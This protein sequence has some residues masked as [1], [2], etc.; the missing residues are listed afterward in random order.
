MKIK[1][2][3]FT[4]C[5]ALGV[6]AA[7]VKIILDSDMF[8]DYDDVGALA[9]LHAFADAGEAE[10]LG[11]GVC[12][13]GATSR[14]VAMIEAVNAFYGRGEL[15]VG[16]VKGK[17]I[18][19]AGA[20]KFLDW[21][22]YAKWIHHPFSESA[23]DVVPM[24][25]RLLAAQSDGSVVMCSLGFMTNL[26][27][28]LESKPDAISPLDGVALVKAKCRLWVTMAC[29][30]PDGKEYNSMK[31]PESSRIAFEKWP[32][33]IIWTDFQY[34]R[35]LYSGRAVAELTD[36]MN[37]VRDA[38]AYNL[39][40]REK[41]VVGKSWDQMAGHPSWDET[42]VLAAVRG[43]GKYFG[44]EHGRFEMIGEQG[45]D[46]WIKDDACKHGRLVVT[47]PREEVG[48]VLDELMCRKPKKTK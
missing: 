14:S 8:T 24:Y 19:G 29:S 18:E 40:P 42:A 16:V 25:R 35:T 32:T 17:A 4:A 38:F 7:P 26:R 34:G 12:T 37:P 1:T 6:M 31:D 43:A 20:E 23:Q 15:P 39:P 9:M 22:K 27:N 13:K 36:A 46:R 11:I 48:K 5:L 10:I 47:M 30:Y 3:I 44:L 45:D 28:L 21:N 33:P 2:L 41:V